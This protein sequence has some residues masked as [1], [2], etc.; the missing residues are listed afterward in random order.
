MRIYILTDLEGV[1]GVVNDSQTMAGQPG[2]ERAREWLTHDVNAA[3]EGAIEGGATDIL[4]LDGHG[5]NSACNLIYDRLHPGAHYIQGTPWTQYLQCL[6]ESF[7][8]LY[9]VGAHAMA[10]TAGAVLEHTMSS[11]NWVGMQ[12]NGEPTGEIGLCAAVAGHFGVPFA[13]ASGDDKACA[14]A[15]AISPGIECAVVKKGI[16]RHCAEMYPMHVV[17]EHIRGAALAAV[18]KAK[19]LKPVQI[20]GPVE[21]LIE[22]L[23]NDVVDGTRERDGVRKMGP[24]EVL[25]TGANLVEAF[26]RVLGG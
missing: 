23:R 9:Q 8:A 26:H 5:A 12:I 25:Y 17:A 3:V 20:K 22:Y 16:S 13:M 14:E 1:G 2:Y 15:A 6:D 19:S 10:G 4:V 18:D 24:R 11:L 7:D 21:I